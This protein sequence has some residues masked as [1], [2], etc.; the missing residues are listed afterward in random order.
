MFISSFI[1]F[2]INRNNANNASKKW[3]N[4]YQVLVFAFVVMYMK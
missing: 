2:S 3:T 4:C 1:N